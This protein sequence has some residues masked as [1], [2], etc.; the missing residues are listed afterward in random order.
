MPARC[1]LKSSAN[2]NVTHR[3]ACKGSALTHPSTA[4][5]NEEIPPRTT[6]QRHAAVSCWSPGG[7]T[8]AWTGHRIQGGKHLPRPA[9]DAPSPGSNDH[10]LKSAAFSTEEL[11]CHREAWFPLRLSS[12][13]LA[14]GAFPLEGD[15]THEHPTQ[16]GP[17]RTTVPCRHP[18]T[19][20]RSLRQTCG[21]RLRAGPAGARGADRTFDGGQNGHLQSGDCSTRRDV[22]APCPH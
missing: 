6:S 4:V 19:V 17:G 9:G 1:G 18:A 12:P 5:N 3:E 11:L 10:P 14:S 8:D 22:C 21:R 2:S 20:S 15:L 13:S 16:H 7:S